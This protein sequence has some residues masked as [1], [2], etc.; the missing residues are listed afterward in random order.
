MATRSPGD[1]NHAPEF[2]MPDVVDGQAIH[3]DVRVAVEGMWK[4]FQ[5]YVRY[6]C[7]SD[8]QAAV[9]AF[10]IGRRVSRHLDSSSD[11][12]RVLNAYCRT[13]ARNV[14]ADALRKKSI[15]L[16]YR[17]LSQDLE[18]LGAVQRAVQDELDLSITL[19][20]LASILDEET[21]AILHARL[22]ERSWADIGPSLNLTPGQ[23]RLRF[24]RAIEKHG[25][26]Q[27]IFGRDRG[28]RGGQ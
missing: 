12:I 24:F 13:T 17:G 25:V 19:D 11:E 10:E 20:Q 18:R 27:K 4:W 3:P 22:L 8:E 28:S 1:H 26:L 2:E 21:M 5:R 6:R 23:A 16:D 15:R 7:G 9:L 14:V